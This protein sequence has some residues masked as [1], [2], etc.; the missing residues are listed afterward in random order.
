M[1]GYSETTNLESGMISV[2]ITNPSPQMFFRLRK[3]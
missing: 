3:P 1:F 2:L